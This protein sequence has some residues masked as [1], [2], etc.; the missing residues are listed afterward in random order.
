MVLCFRNITKLKTGGVIGLTGVG[1]ELKGAAEVP[2]ACS[3]TSAHVEHIGSEWGE[4]L[5]IGIS[6]RCFD[7]AVASFILV[8]MK[9]TKRVICDYN[10]LL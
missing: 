5:D 7:D 3:G 10:I 8:L 4:A 9:E 6:R 2:V 1:H